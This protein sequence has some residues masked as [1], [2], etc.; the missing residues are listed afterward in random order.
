MS[1][2]DTTKDLSALFTQQVKATP[3]A[4]ALEDEKNTYTYQQ[5]HDKVS[6]LALQLR[7]HGVGRDSLVGV[8][9]PRSADYVIACLA[10][11][12]AGGA[13]N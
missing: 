9:L 13:S 1:I 7:G 6:E 11:L 12:A 10:A 5:L 3:D 2:I 8:L 4:I